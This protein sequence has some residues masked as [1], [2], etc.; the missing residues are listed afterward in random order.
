MLAPPFSDVRGDSALAGRNFGR[1]NM[2]DD[3]DASG[4]SQPQQAEPLFHAPWPSVALCVLILVLY[5]VQ[6]TLLT[7]PNALSALWF[8]PR[9][10]EAGRWTGL[11]TSI[12]LHGGWPHAI[13]NAGFALAFA[14]PVSRLFGVDARGVMNFFAFYV[15]CGVLANLGFAILPHHPGEVL[16]GA[17]GAISGLAGAASRLM[18]R[19]EAGRLAP[20]TSPTVVGMTAAWVTSNLLVGVFGVTIL[21]GGAGIAWQAHVAGYAAGLVLIGPLVAILGLLKFEAEG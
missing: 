17:S 11:V 14:A 18:G 15:A 6:S 1:L 10:L 13:F 20:F 4:G 9:E 21:T 3:G 19:R 12:F 5:G 2:I 16:V 7:A 8:S